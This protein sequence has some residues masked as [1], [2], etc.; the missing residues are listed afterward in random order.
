MKVYIMIKITN[1]KIKFLKKLLSFSFVVIIL[2]GS[3]VLG[4]EEVAIYA[5]DYTKDFIIQRASNTHNNSL[6]GF[7][8]HGVE[9]DVLLNIGLTCY[10]ACVQ[11]PLEER[12]ENRWVVTAAT[13]NDALSAV[14]NDLENISPLNCDPVQFPK[15]AADLL[16]SNQLYI[17]GFTLIGTMPTGSLTQSGFFD[18]K[19]PEVT[20]FQLGVG[21]GE[22]GPTIQITQAPF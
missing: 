11:C 5:V 19:D 3:K 22:E 12:Q 1:Y 10:Y 18:W 4:M 7:K 9:V 15:L 20:N 2:M 13:L 17:R 16:K 6:L 14:E 8:P 21:Q